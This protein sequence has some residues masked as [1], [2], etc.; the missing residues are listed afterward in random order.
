MSILIFGERGYLGSYLAE[1]C[2]EFPQCSMDYVINCAGLVSVELSE[3]NPDRSYASNVDVVK[4]LIT[5][6]PD[7]KIIQFSSYYVYD[8]PNA[9]CNEMDETTDKYVYM[10]HKL[11]GERYALEAGGVCFRLGKL[12]GHPDLQKQN[13]LT[14]CI[15]KSEG[16]MSLDDVVFNP[17]S[18]ETVFEVIKHE[19]LFHDLYGLY[20]LSDEGTTTHYEYGVYILNALGIK[21][22]PK[23]E[24]TLK[25]FHNFGNFAMDINKIKRKVFIQHWTKRMDQYLKGII[26]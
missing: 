19:L 10:K 20:N 23:M 21:T 16:N 24:K 9:L 1:K 11:L 18:L 3:E 4:K 2:H 12:Y 15:I 6:H 13:R 22:V 26:C 8:K 14:E 25:L 7:S 17:T 5:E